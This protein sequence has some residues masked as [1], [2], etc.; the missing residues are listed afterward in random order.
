MILVVF[1]AASPIFLLSSCTII[2]R[3][4]SASW[5]GCFDNIRHRSRTTIT[6][7]LYLRAPITSD[8]DPAKGLGGIKG[9]ISLIVS[10][11]IA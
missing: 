1:S 5:H 10:I 7:S 3:L 6:S 2:I 11:L 4:L 8:G 9:I